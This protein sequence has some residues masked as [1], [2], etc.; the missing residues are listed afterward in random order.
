MASAHDNSPQ[1]SAELV[2]QIGEALRHLHE[3]VLDDLLRLCVVPQERVCEPHHSGVLGSVQEL[4]REAGSRSDRCALAVAHTRHPP[5]AHGIRKVLQPIRGG[6]RAGRGQVWAS[7]AMDVATGV[8]IS[9]VLLTVHKRSC[10]RAMAS[11]RIS[12]AARPPS[13]SGKTTSKVIA[14]LTRWL[15]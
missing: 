4:E 6:V 7:P 14:R 3:R 12:A 1:V 10:E 9:I 13:S 11:G 2:S 8:P 15:P 5:T